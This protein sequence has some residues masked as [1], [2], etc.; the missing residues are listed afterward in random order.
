VGFSTDI[1]LV[2]LSLQILCFLES[3]A[4]I[5]FNIRL[6]RHSGCKGT[7]QL[8]QNYFRNGLILD[9]LAASPFN[10]VLSIIGTTSPIY[11]IAPLRLLRVFAIGRIPSLL[12]KMEIVF[13]QLGKYITLIKTILF[14]VF[15]WH[16]SSCVWFFVNLEV[17][18]DTAFTWADYHGVEN[19]SLYKQYLMATYFTMNIVTSVGYGD[20]F[21]TT[22]NERLTTCLIILTGD[23]LFAV[24]F[25]MMASLAEG[26]KSELS[27]Y[28]A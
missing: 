26:N 7:K 13:I 24:A 9:I 8:V 27:A 21:G 6:I 17:D 16:T 3:L 28:L 15:L 4:Y 19:D 18:P 11:I 23:A 2:I 22:D 20:M 25:G 12:E 14:L 1:D 10:I 5:M